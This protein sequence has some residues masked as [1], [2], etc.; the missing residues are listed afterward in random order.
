MKENKRRGE[1]KVCLRPYIKIAFFSALVCLCVGICLF[2]SLFFDGYEEYRLIEI[3]NL[4]GTPKK[5]I[6]VPDGVELFYSYE[7]SDEKDVG[8]VIYQS[9]VGK[10]K[11]RGDYPL[12]I[13]IGRER[14]FFCVP[15]LHGKTKDEAVREIESLGGVAIVEYIDTGKSGCVSYQS[16]HVGERLSLGDRVTI[17]VSR[18]SGNESVRVPSLEGLNFGEAMLKIQESGLALGDID[19][20]LCDD[21]EGGVVLLQSLPY[22]MYARKNTKINLTVS[23]KSETNQTKESHKNIWMTKK[24]AE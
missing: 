9:A 3:P 18:K 12:Y 19:Y 23:K 21:V 17:F 5:D 11:S 8:R 13:K 7:Y 14:E 16:P 24:R 20:A 22:G 4:C 1:R 10:K 6:C 15:S 2:A